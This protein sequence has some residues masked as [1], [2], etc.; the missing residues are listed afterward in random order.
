MHVT[1]DMEEQIFEF[2]HA[3]PLWSHERAETFK[4]GVKTC[5]HHVTTEEHTR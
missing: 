5:D 2:E 4:T 3:I 1:Y